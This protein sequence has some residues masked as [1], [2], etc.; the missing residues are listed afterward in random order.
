MSVSRSLHYKHRVF[1]AGQLAS[2]L[3]SV[4]KTVGIN[5]NTELF[6]LEETLSD[7]TEVSKEVQVRE[8][9]TVCDVAKKSIRLIKSSNEGIFI[10]S[11]YSIGTHHFRL[12]IGA[13][14]TK[15]LNEIRVIL[16]QSLQLQESREHEGNS[17]GKTINS[18]VAEQI[19][20]ILNRLEQ[21]E[22]IILAPT[23]RLRCFLS[24]RFTDSNTIVA[25]KI[26][27]FLTLLNVDVIT[28][29][30]YEPR[31]VSEK[32]LSRLREPLDF[33]LLLM[34][35]NGESMWT[36]DEIGTAIHRG[37][38]LV[39]LIEIGVEFEPGLFADVEYVEFAPGH[40]GDAFLKILQAVHFVREQ[41]QVN[42]S[43]DKI[44]ESA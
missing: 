32:V 35:N 15:I 4:M 36:R 6:S 21:L 17:I 18:I 26:Q 43:A 29:A 13:P 27:Q 34:T 8:L 19:T 44:T 16:E 14:T 11:M 9:E 37:I 7:G 20:P 31:Q 1:E 5:P 28:G 25:L 33:I 40:I 42:I 39:P 22:E 12:R 3:E 41:K 23:R 38:A 24:Y 2:A 10:L 30:T